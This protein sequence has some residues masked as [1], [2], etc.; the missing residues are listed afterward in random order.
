MTQEAYQTV[1]EA[2]MNAEKREEDE[3]ELIGEFNNSKINI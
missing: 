3:L 1:A 2:T